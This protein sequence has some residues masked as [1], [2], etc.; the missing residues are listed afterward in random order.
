VITRTGLRQK[1]A[2]HE[3]DT[4]TILKRIAATRRR[5][6]CVAFMGLVSLVHAGD[7]DELLRSAG[8][9]L[10]RYYRAV[11]ILEQSPNATDDLPTGNCA[12]DVKAWQAKGVKDGERIFSYDFNQH[13]KA[14]NNTIAM[15]DMVEVCA[16]FG[17][18]SAGSRISAD[19]IRFDGVLMRIRDKFVKPGDSVLTATVIDTYEKDGSPAAC[20]ATVAAARQRNPALVIRNGSRRYS[21]GEFDTKVCDELAR[22]QPAFIADARAALRKANEKTMAP[23]IAA[24]IGGRKLDLMIRYDGVYWRLPGGDRTDDPKKLAAAPTLF[25]WLEAEDRDD[26]AYVIH[27]IRKFQFKGNDLAGVSEKAYRAKKGAVLG[28]VFE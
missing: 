28:N 15:A 18:L 26:P 21:L 22:L 3:I 9:Q 13:P 12:A 8:D 14:K 6:A 20:K 16:R 24:G 11:L 2:T 25:Q 23:Y 27:T 17:T 1:R 4:G 10:G 5:A 7:R 19:L